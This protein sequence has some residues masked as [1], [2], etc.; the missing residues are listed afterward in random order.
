MTKWKTNKNNK[1]KQGAEIPQSQ[2]IAVAFILLFTI[3]CFDVHII[4]CI[5][6]YFEILSVRPGH[7]HLLCP[8]FLHLGSLF[9][10]ALHNYVYDTFWSVALIVVPWG[11]LLYPLWLCFLKVVHLKLPNETQNTLKQPLHFTNQNEYASKRT[12]KLSQ[13][14]RC[15]TRETRYPEMGRYHKYPS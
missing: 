10:S 2:Q 8:R 15:P 14:T 4:T 11:Q 13:A 1:Y 9:W 6:T 12:S 3:F 5:N 7:L